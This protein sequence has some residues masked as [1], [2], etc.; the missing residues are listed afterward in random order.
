MAQLI[1]VMSVTRV[2][3][4]NVVVHLLRM[5][6]QVGMRS[7]PLVLVM[8]MVGVLVLMHMLMAHLFVMMFMSMS[9]LR[10]DPDPKRHQACGNDQGY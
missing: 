2:R 1:M 9:L 10:D 7:R 5:V 4:M 6:M 8:N 3:P